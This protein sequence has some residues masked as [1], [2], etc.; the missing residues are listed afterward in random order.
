MIK[1]NLSYGVIEDRRVA[2]ITPKAT[3]MSTIWFWLKFSLDTGFNKVIL[4]LDCL[5]VVH[6]INSN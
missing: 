3:K 4:E 2:R 5:Q 6:L 1:N